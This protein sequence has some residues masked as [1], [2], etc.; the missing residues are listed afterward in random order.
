MEEGRLY[1]VIFKSDGDEQE[2][3]LLYSHMEGER[4]V[5]QDPDTDAP[6]ILHV[7]SVLEVRPAHE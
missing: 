5:W 7:K 3:L 4:W 6:F 2:G 1:R